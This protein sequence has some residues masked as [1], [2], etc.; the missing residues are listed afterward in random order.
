MTE[1]QVDPMVG[2]RM[3]SVDEGQLVGMTGEVW[4]PGRNQAH[5]THVGRP[6]HKRKVWVNDPDD[7][8][9][10]IQTTAGAAGGH[11]RI[12]D[13]GCGCGLWAYRSESMCREVLSRPKLRPVI[14]GMFGR[15]GQGI[16]GEVMGRVLAWGRVLIGEDGFRAE[17]AKITALITTE[18]LRDVAAFY[19]VP[20]VAPRTKDEEGIT[21][22]WVDRVEGGEPTIVSLVTFGDDNAGGTFLADPAIRI[23]AGAHVRLSFERR[24]SVRWITHEIELGNGDNE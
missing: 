10:L 4:V 15:F 21:E 24:G 17:F 6:A 2:Y 1:L 14:R 8:D 3:F 20:I 19:G 9:G 18:L 13:P 5:C 7:S 16:E 23:H 11:G 22:G 12:P